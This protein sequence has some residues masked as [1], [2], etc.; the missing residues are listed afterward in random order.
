[1]LF[2]LQDV[3]A[4][5]LETG[6]DAVAFARL[7][8]GQ[9]VEVTVDARPGEA[10]RGKL[11]VLSPALDAQ[12]RRAS[13]EVEIDNAAGRLLP[14]MFAHAEIT[15]GVAKDALVIPREALLDAPGGATVYRVREGQAEAVQ[16]RCASG[17]AGRVRVLSALHE[18]DEVA[19]SG[20]A[21]LSDGAP[22]RVAPV[23]L[24][25]AGPQ[26]RRD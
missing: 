24:Q 15:V 4:L 16:P 2:T 17:D 26:E 18:G 13:I 25:A 8:R 20:L 23:G 10:F 3:A 7:A 22:V 19:T 9:P 1:V 5:K 12:T 11:A 6:V 14:N 21:S